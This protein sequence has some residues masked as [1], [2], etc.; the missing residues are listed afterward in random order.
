MCHQQ[1]DSS[2]VDPAKPDGNY[3]NG[4]SIPNR[5]PSCAE[6]HKLILRKFRTISVKA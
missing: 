2:A 5:G 4:I 3:P 6:N 1:N